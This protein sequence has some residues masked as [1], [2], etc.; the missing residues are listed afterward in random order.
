M[1]VANKCAKRIENLLWFF[2]VF[3]VHLQ[4]IGY[5]KKYYYKNLVQ[6]PIKALMFFTPRLDGTEKHTD[7]LIL[8][9][10]LLGLQMLHFAHSVTLKDQE[11]IFH[12]RR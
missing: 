9:C 4:F 10:L 5:Y 7:F 6:K 11:V 12:W 1:S 3:F 8:I 2:V